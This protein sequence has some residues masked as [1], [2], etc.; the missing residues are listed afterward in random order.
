MIE[1]NPWTQNQDAFKQQK[2]NAWSFNQVP[3]SKDELFFSK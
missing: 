1:P 3:S 2:E